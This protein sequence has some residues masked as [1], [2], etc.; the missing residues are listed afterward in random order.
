MQVVEFTETKSSLRKVAFLMLS[1]PMA[2]QNTPQKMGLGKLTP[3]A[4]GVVFIVEEEAV[5]N[6]ENCVTAISGKD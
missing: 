4:A 3:A 1:S 5:W 6:D 2:P